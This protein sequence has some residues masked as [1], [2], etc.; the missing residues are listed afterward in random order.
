MT[1]YAIRCVGSTDLIHMPEGC[2]EEGARRHAVEHAAETRLI[3]E[4]LRWDNAAGQWEQV[5]EVDPT[6]FRKHPHDKLRADNER[7]RR[8]VRWVASL[9]QPDPEPGEE[10]ARLS[11]NR[12]KLAAL[13]RHELDQLKG[14]D[15]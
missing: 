11:L 15:Q 8:F 12:D 14:A 9:D 2:A 5:L 6:R 10:G 13:A 4:A 3:V 1:R 7:L